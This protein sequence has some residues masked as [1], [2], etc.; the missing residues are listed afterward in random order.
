ML[1]KVVC[2]VYII[3]FLFDLIN[4]GGEKFVIG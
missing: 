3:S 1:N 4:G 2:I